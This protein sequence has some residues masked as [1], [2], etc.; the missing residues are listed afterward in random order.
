MHVNATINVPLSIDDRSALSFLRG[1]FGS[2]LD[3]KD[4]SHV[5]ESLSACL[6]VHLVA[7]R[8]RETGRNYFAVKIGDRVHKI[9]SGS[10]TLGFLSDPDGY[11][12]TS[13][14]LHLG[15][16]IANLLNDSP[17]VFVGL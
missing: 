8:S 15:G 2:H 3:S 7:V 13:I 10:D 17:Y 11:P 12:P 14:V 5:L 6:G 4:A 1:L 16:P 9:E